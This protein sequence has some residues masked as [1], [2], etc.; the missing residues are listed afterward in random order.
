MGANF[1]CPNSYKRL[2]E[3]FFFIT[4]AQLAVARITMHYYWYIISSM[5]L[6]C[7]SLVLITSHSKIYLNFF[8]GCGLETRQ[9]AVYKIYCTSYLALAQPLHP[10]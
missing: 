3:N 9:K 5:G 10:K 1:K 8:I 6:Q 4:G 7:I 2:V